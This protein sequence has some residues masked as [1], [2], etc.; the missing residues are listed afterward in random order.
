MRGQG[1]GEGDRRGKEGGPTKGLSETREGE[2]I[3]AG[4]ALCEVLSRPV[5]HE[6][7]IN[8]L[9]DAER[10]QIQPSRALADEDKLW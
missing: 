8:V 2:Q 5:A 9:V 6:G 1:E 3:C 7:G 10:F 4:V